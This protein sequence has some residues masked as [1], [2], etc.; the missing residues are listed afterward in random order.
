MVLSESKFDCEA[1]W[2][3]D[4]SAMLELYFDIARGYI[5]RRDMLPLRRKLDGDHVA[6]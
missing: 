6:A 3:R 2:A 4:V 1:D 5:R